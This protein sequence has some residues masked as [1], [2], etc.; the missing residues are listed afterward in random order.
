MANNWQPKRVD[1]LILMV[2]NL[3]RSVDFYKN[4]LKL[5]LRLQSPTWAEFVVGETHLALHQNSHIKFSKKDRSSIQNIIFQFEVDNL[6]DHI[7][8]LR[9]HRI[10]LVGE[11][12]D[13]KYARYAY[14]EDPD[15]YILGFCEY[16]ETLQEIL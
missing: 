9:L 6:E 16:K 2:S 14:F 12:S 13:S 11:V 4:I 3:D 5:S 1:T 15:G 7:E 10:E 8:F